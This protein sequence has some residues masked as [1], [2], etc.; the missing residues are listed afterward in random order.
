M[1]DDGP[2]EMPS[3]YSLHVI[4]Y[5]VDG[6][7]DTCLGDQPKL[8]HLS[9]DYGG[10]RILLPKPG[11]NERLVTLHLRHSSTTALEALKFVRLFPL[12]QDLALESFKDTTRSCP[13]AVKYVLDSQVLPSLRIMSL[14]DV[15]SSFIWTF[16]NPPLIREH[17]FVYASPLDEPF[18]GSM[19]IR[20][21]PVKAV[22]IDFLQ[23][24]IV[25][26]HD[27]AITK[28]IYMDL[29]PY[30]SRLP[31]H[32]RLGSLSSFTMT[33]GEPLTATELSFLG[34]LTKLSFTYQPK[35]V[36][37]SDK[38]YL[39]KT[40]NETLAH[41]CRQLVH[42]DIGLEGSITPHDYRL[43]VEGIL[44]DFAI[45][46]KNI[47]HDRFERLCLHDGIKT[48]VWTPPEALYD[49]VKSLEIGPIDAF[50]SIPTFPELHWFRP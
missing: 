29:T 32:V 34:N 6:A 7:L 8:R 9:I 19:L 44:V 22:W 27:T 43:E 10:D 13:Q 48:D 12:L 31:K 28:V 24:H 36:A 26:Y 4:H 2:V 46:W 17:T 47:Y 30:T 37:G 38:K 25:F 50:T 42:L 5:N 21:D 18:T 45:A 15:A 20:E 14:R 41:A 3:L 39:S 40:L 23:K 11:W 1:D 33:N 49:L 35:H 16:L